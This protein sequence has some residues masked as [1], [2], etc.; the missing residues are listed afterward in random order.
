MANLGSCRCILHFDLARKHN[1]T[2][3][4]GWGGGFKPWRNKARSIWRK[5][6]LR[7]FWASFLKFAR[8]KVRHRDGPGNSGKF[9]FSAEFPQKNLVQ[10]KSGKFILGNPF[11]SIWGDF[12]GK[13]E[14][15][16]LICWAEVRV[17]FLMGSTLGPTMTGPKA[18]HHP[19]IS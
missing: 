18:T 13:W 9:R 16:K 7:N 5:N 17:G 8:P 4:F 1:V 11:S 15:P 3:F 19:P 12:W 6:S 14:W 2:F 10:G